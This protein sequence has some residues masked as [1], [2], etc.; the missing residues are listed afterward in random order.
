MIYC[1]YIIA[2]FAFSSLP[3]TWSIDDML[4]IIHGSMSEVLCRTGNLRS[5]HIP[6]YRYISFYTYIYEFY[7]N[8]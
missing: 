5:Q 8:R 3:L 1:H 7:I 2:R 4:R 6:D